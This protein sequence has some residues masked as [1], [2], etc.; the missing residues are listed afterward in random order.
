[1]LSLKTCIDEISQK[2]TVE[3]VL[4]SQTIEVGKNLARSVV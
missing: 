2:G 3:F 4:L 1:M